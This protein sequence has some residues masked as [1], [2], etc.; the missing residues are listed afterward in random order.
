[1]LRIIL[2]RHGETEWN[3]QRRYQGHRDLPLS[4]AG[5]WQAERVAQRL[6]TQRLQAVYASDLQRARQTA[7][8]IARPHGLPVLTRPGLRE[9]DFGEW[10]GY[11]HAE[12]L[13][14]YPDLLPRWVNEVTSVRVPGGE[15]LHEVQARVMKEW[16]EITAAHPEGTLA[17]VAHGG[18]IR[19]L[20][21]SLRG[22]PLSAFWD[23]VIGPASISVVQG[24]EGY[25]R[26]VTSN[27]CAH[28]EGDALNKP[29]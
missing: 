5:R 2:V 8:A 15:T 18:T 11:T 25:F 7:E 27:D 21:L 17:V 9:M 29:R 14:R 28:L 22:E 26:A 19:V 3:H 23:L 12:L 10:E 6:A 1:L 4:P 24:E 13:E 20:L 16:D